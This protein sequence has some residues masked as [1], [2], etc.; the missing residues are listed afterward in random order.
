MKYGKKIFPAIALALCAT[1]FTACAA[2]NQK[3]T[4][5]EYW[6]KDADAPP[7][8]APA[9]VLETLEYE[10]KFEKAS[11]FGDDYTVDYQNGV[12]TTKLSLADDEYLYETS[13]SIDVTYT[14]GGKSETMSDSIV[15]WVK[16]KK[17]ANLQ[18]IASHKELFCHS[19]ESGGST[20]ETCFS[21]HNYTVENTYNANGLG[22]KSVI[23][24]NKTNE[25]REQ[26]F[27]VED[28]YACLDNEQLLFALRG[29]SQ[30][31][32]SA[33]VSVYAPFSGVVQTINI[34]YDT[35]QE[36]KEFTFAQNGVSNTQAINYYP[37]S[38]KIN[39]QLPGATQTVWIA[40]TTKT[41]SNTFRNVI[42]QLE[43]PLSYNLGSLIYTLKSA[44]FI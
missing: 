7:A 13:L 21:E 26:T 42:L 15:T 30:S 12:Y 9:T 11:G 8:V 44:T 28:K 16:F 43:T 14:A 4:F 22:G 36:G 39:A 18:P 38:L 25:S 34:S 24:N 41:Y 33:S 40:Q 35:L 5:N 1:T 32:S 31:I 19:P 23:V 17:G 10:V 37:I 6:L 20:I 3:V 27:T 2:T 29:L